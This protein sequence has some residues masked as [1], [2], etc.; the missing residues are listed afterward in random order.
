MQTPRANG[1]CG[2]IE[3]AVRWKN[4]GQGRL[5]VNTVLLYTDTVLNYSFKCGFPHY[6]HCKRTAPRLVGELK[7]V[8]ITIIITAKWRSLSTR[9]YTMYQLG[10]F[11]K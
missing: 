3:V 4:H 7:T 5:I 10:W 8:I 11:M 1:Q 6:F 9:V 2:K